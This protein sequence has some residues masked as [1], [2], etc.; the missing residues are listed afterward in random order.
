MIFCLVLSLI[1]AELA[2]AEANQLF[3]TPSSLQMNIN[4]VFDVKVSSYADSDAS[5]GTASGT[6]NY[7]TD[8]L[9]VVSL[10]TAGSGYGTPSLSQG[11]GAVGFNGTRSPAYS[12]PALIF[13]IKFKAINSGSAAVSFG[14]GSNVNNQTTTLKSGA[15]TITNPN[16]P[17]SSSPS[18]TPKPSTKPKPSTA[19]VIT[20]PT[21]TVEPTEGPVV[22]PDPT[23]VVDNVSVVP[24]YGSATVTW[25]VN[26]A[27]PNSTFVYGFSTSQMDKKVTATKKSDGT[28]EA[29]VTGLSPGTR[30]IFYITGSG[31]GQSGNYTSTIFTRGYPVTITV[32]E[33]NVPVSKGQIRIGTINNS[34]NSTGISTIGLAA[35]SYT[36]TITTETASLSISLTVEAKTIPSNGS[37]PES[38]LARFNLTS[39]PLA[40]GPGSGTSVITFVIVLAG[41][42][43][44]LGLGF[45]GFMAY[46]R[47]RYDVDSDA[48]ISYGSAGPSV[49]IDDGYTWQND[50]QHATPAAPPP[51]P[52]NTSLPL[53]PELPPQHDNSVY[54]SEEEPVD[55]F[56][57]GLKKLPPLPGEK[58]NP[59]DL[60]VTQQNPNLPHS[61]KL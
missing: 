41:G 1:P 44:L 35:G 31:G 2:F 15:Y 40:Q 6:V 11:S 14:G 13:T 22:T 36:G 48:D 3:V 58:I 27:N 33:N 21:P 23:G 12:G 34:I 4:N 7:P 26:A 49:V 53:P 38:Q 17:P 29:L 52:A 43:L 16:P 32:T 18:S 19:P 9:Q 5:S 60:D 25:K 50:P 51:P 59:S 24:L 10:S 55:M 61:T 47:K 39:S 42:A 45:V 54:L 57:Q 46:R 8:K 56:E 37:A 30:Y 20:T 28:F